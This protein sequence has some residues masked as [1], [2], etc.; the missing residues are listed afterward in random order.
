MSMFDDMR[1]QGNQLMSDPDTREKVRRIA[2][3][4]GMTL[5]EAKIHYLRQ[6]AE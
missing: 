6:Q 2:D 3:E 5:D 1:D 4:H